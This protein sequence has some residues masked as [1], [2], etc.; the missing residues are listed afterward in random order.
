MAELDGKVALAERG[1]GIIVT[2]TGRPPSLRGPSTR[3]LSAQTTSTD[4]GERR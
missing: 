3:W 4:G 1:A 2:G